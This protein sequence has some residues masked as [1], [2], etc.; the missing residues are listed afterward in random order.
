M[1]TLSSKKYTNYAID[2]TNNRVQ[3]LK[4]FFSFELLFV[5]FLFAGLYKGD[6]RLE[7]LPIDLTALFFALS[8][9][10]GLIIIIKRGMVFN[11][12]AVIL[13]MLY[14]GFA[15]YVLLSY[16]WTP[17]KVYSTQKMLYIWTLVLWALAA[18]AL[19]IST[20]PRRI[21]RLGILFILLSIIASFEA[22]SQYI[23]AGQSGFIGVFG[24]NYLG[25]GR[26]AGLAFIVSYTYALFGSCNPFAK[27]IA[28]ILAGV[29]LCILLIGG[30]RGPFIA[31]IL[32]AL[33]PAFFSIHFSLKRQSI[34]IKPFIRPIVVITIALLFLFGYFYETGHMTQTMARLQVLTSDGM[35]DSAAAR[36]QHYTH[37]IQ[38]W[39]QA[40]LFGNGIGSWPI[41]NGDT[42]MRSYPH[43]LILEILT[44]LGLM[45]LM[46]FFTLIL[47]A[48][49]F[50]KPIKSEGYQSI[51]IVLLMIVMYMFLNSMVSGDIPDNRLL[52]ASIGLIPAALYCKEKKYV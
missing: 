40:P 51:N 12:K 18:P 52:F 34:K 20:D 1:K 26:I 31:T 2:I 14:I 17:G 38:Y 8:L 24:S 13:C 39:K 15:L 36:I 7:W 44:E 45:G 10:S 47:Y 49:R 21:K 33:I 27:L 3:I 23:Q 5:L 19:I 6:P 32:S 35:G 29:F 22:I 43:N 48:L 4:G 50:L 46:L 42:D 37:A 28:I 25:L 30:A 16:L 11:Q 9:I 41:I